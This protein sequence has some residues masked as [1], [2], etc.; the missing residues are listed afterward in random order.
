MLFSSQHQSRVLAVKRC[1]HVTEDSAGSGG[2]AKPTVKKYGLRVQK[3]DYL[4][5]GSIPSIGV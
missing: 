3:V 4:L 2:E 1:Q 5:L